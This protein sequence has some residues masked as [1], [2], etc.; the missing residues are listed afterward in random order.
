MNS[1]K[2]QLVDNDYVVRAK[3]ELVLNGIDDLLGKFVRQIN[4]ELIVGEMAF[5]EI[6]GADMKS[7]TL[8]VRRPE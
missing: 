5:L 2:I 4:E 6:E 8:E 1:I 3:T 7:V